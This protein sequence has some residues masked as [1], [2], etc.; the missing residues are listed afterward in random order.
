MLFEITNQLGQ[1]V[2]TVEVKTG[3]NKIILNGLSQ[4]IYLLI[5]NSEGKIYKGKMT[6]LH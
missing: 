4:G 2:K 5:G 6:I 1:L 3:Q